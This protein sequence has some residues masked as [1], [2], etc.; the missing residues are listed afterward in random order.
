LHCDP[1]PKPQGQHLGLRSVLRDKIR[2]GRETE[3]NK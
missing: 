1:S 3:T 2:F